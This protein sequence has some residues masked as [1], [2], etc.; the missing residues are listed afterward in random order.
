MKKTELLF[1]EAFAASL[2]N[3]SVT[4]AGSFSAGEWNSLFS[5]ASSHRILPMICE[6]VYTC[7]SAQAEGAEALALAKRESA[8]LVMMQVKKTDEFIEI[9]RALRAAGACPIVIKGIICRNLYPKPDL[10]MSGDEDILIR[11][12]EFELCDR[13][14]KEHGLLRAE[15]GA[16]VQSAFEITYYRPGS[17]IYIELHKSL[18]PPEQNA[19]GNLNSY[20]EDCH[21]RAVSVNIQ[22]EEILTMAPDDH[23]FYLICHAF[24]HFIHSG[25]GIRQTADICMFAEKYGENIA[26]GI[27]LEKCRKINADIFAA[28][29]FKTGEKYLGFDTSKAC[30]S[31]GW[32]DIDVDETAFLE[33]ILDSG[34][35]GNSSMSRKHSGSIT[36]NA[37]ASKKTGKKRISLVHT[38]FPP[39]SELKGRFSYLE[40]Y[41]V[42]L[43]I[44]WAA[45]LFRYKKET[46]GAG[47]GN[48]AVCSVRIGKKRIELLKKY[49]IIK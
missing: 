33:D 32:G 2:K 24:K 27:L 17:M 40:K 36:L 6:A 11:P 46:S 1:L 41:T 37:V 38:V 4:W 5:L 7:P 20:F 8:R 22:G 34:V 43:P 30:I 39:A 35:Y 3:K 10:R 13:V 31:G 29:I 49:K 48:S 21:K 25:V 45:R 14:F 16:D 19:F 28:A 44:A 47:A 9:Y 15:P 12:K 18:F 42:L 23:L 26:W